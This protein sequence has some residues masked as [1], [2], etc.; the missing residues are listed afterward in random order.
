MKHRNLDC[1]RGC[2]MAGHHTPDCTHTNECPDTCTDHCEGCL[3]REAETGNYCWRCTNKFR[4]ALNE[5][6]GLT[7]YLKALPEGKLAA[8]NGDRSTSDRRATKVDQMSPS[9]AYDELDEVEAWVFSWA[10]NL[11]DDLH[12]V[13]PFRYRKDGIP[14][15]TKVDV[16]T[17]YLTS[18]I[19]EVLS[20]DWHED[21]YGEA[22]KLRRRLELVTGQDQLVHRINE[23]CPTCDR[24]TLTREDGADK[25]ICRNHDCN[26]VWTEAEYARLAHVAA[27]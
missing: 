3:P 19:T 17:N 1:A 8:R 24:R 9:P 16:H 5:L 7:Q 25:V 11:A 15:T 13:G 6:C 23:P 20:A 12:Q 2:L 26:R 21:I 14:D 10:L 4:D 18:H 22:L 27:S